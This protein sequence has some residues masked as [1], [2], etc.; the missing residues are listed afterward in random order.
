[1]P[2]LLPVYKFWHVGI[3]SKAEELIGMHEIGVI[4]DDIKGLK[5]IIKYPVD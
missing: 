1:M 4:G 2:L 5:L 3:E